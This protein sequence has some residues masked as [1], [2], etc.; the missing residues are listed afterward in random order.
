[1]TQNDIHWPDL[2][3]LLD[4]L[5]L[6]ANQSEFHCWQPPIRSH[7]VDKSPSDFITDN[8]RRSALLLLSSQSQAFSTVISVRPMTGGLNCHCW[9][10]KNLL[11][12]RWFLYYEYLLILH[13]WVSLAL[14]TNKKLQK[15]S[16]NVAQV[17][18]IET[19]S[20]EPIFSCC[21]QLKV[22][23]AKRYC[24]ISVARN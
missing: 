19:E 9:C 12:W 3:L 1:M 4:L 21:L 22:C 11:R 13:L 2:L 24:T 6:M 18:S 14:G 15:L 23:N 8:N 7:I 20:R 17:F 10:G 16:T 5:L